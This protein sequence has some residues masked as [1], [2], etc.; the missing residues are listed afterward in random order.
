MWRVSSIMKSLD[1]CLQASVPTCGSRRC[2][3]LVL[4][5][6]E[7]PDH[8]GED[9]GIGDVVTLAHPSLFARRD[10]PTHSRNPT[11]TERDG[12]REKMCVRHHV[13]AME[14]VM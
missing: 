4:H 14:D 9:F 12:R 3:L 13:A 5:L 2:A 11:T 1:I 6:P 10:G 7:A 8:G